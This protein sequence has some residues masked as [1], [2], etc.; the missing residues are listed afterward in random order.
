MSTPSNPFNEC[1]DAPQANVER[2]RGIPMGGVTPGEHQR[3]LFP[4]RTRAWSAVWPQAFVRP[5]KIQPSTIQSMK[6]PQLATKYGVSIRTITSWRRRGAPLESSSKMKAWLAERNIVNPRTKTT[7]PTSA[8]ASGAEARRRY[9]LAQAKRQELF[10]ARDKGRLMDAGVVQ[11]GISKAMATLFAELDRV[12]A[13]DLPC[14]LKGLA[15]GEIR[16]KC[17]EHIERLKR[18]L[19]EALTK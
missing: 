3:N 6:N 9:Y 2:L 16:I 7:E 15:E 14:V 18:Q 4:W 5:P 17:I 1:C 12:F 11:D 13:T 10:L 8:S 19:R